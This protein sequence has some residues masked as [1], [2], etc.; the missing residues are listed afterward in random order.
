MSSLGAAGALVL[1]LL[2]AGVLAAVGDIRVYRIAAPVLT[3]VAAFL[4]LTGGK[5]RG[6]LPLGSIA[7][8]LS[9]IAGTVILILDPF[10]SEDLPVYIVVAAILGA[11]IWESI[12]LLNL[13]N[14]S[15]SN[16]M[17]QFE[18]HQ[19]GEDLA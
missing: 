2:I 19:G 12:D 8:L 6:R 15:C 9:M 4:T 3:I 16:P 1:I 14:R 10:H 7:A 5:K 13:H 18:T 11:I 17:P